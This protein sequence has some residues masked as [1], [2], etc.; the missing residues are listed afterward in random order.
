LPVKILQKLVGEYFGDIPFLNVTF[1]SNLLFKVLFF[2]GNSPVDLSVLYPDKY[3]ELEV[4][5]LAAFRACL[6]LFF[7]PWHSTSHTFCS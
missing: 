4:F 5:Q 7:V 3:F 6:T 1:C 2:Y